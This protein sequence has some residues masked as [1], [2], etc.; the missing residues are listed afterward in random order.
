M[1][2]DTF[3]SKLLQNQKGVTMPAAAYVVDLSTPA[4]AIWI[5][6]AM[7]TDEEGVIARMRRKAG[8]NA[9]PIFGAEAISALSFARSGNRLSVCDGKGRVFVFNLRQNRYKRVRDSGPAVSAAAFNP[10]RDELVRLAQH[11]IS[12]HW[13]TMLDGSWC[14]DRNARSDAYDQWP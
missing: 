4:G 13:H 14:R 10:K 3:V 6:R 11:A 2:W 9:V 12:C 1:R 8:A 7:S 5:S